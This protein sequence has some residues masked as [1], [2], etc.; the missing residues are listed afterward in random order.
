MPLVCMNQIRALNYMKDHKKEQ[1]GPAL[2]ELVDFDFY[3]SE[4]RVVHIAS[5]RTDL[6]KVRF[7]RHGWKN[8]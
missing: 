5:L 1:S 7:T 3:R 8:T 4:S 6:P 2:Y